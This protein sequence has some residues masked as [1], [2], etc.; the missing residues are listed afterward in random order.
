MFFMFLFY[1]HK[2]EKISNLAHDTHKTAHHQSKSSFN[3]FIS[4]SQSN[5]SQLPKNSFQRTKSLFSSIKNYLGL[6]SIYDPNSVN[7]SLIAFTKQMCLS[8]N[9]FDFAL[10]V[11]FKWIR[12]TACVQVS[13]PRD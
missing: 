7:F 12:K 4:K 13:A 9:A 3:A 2:K 1:N 11:G 5:F 8:F 10:I 6:V